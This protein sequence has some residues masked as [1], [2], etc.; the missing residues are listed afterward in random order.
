MENSK[1]IEKNKGLEIPDAFYV[2]SKIAAYLAGELTEK[3]KQELECW[4]EAD[5]ENLRLFEQIVSEENRKRNREE[6]QAFPEGIGWEEFRHKRMRRRLNVYYRWTVYAAVVLVSF[7]LSYYFLFRQQPISLPGRQMTYLPGAYRAQL[8]LSDGKVIDL[9][10]YQ[11]KINLNETMAV[12][13]NQD[14]RLSY[15]DTLMDKKADM[16]VVYNQIDVPKC[17]EYQLRL[18]D[19]SVV[20]LN[21]QTRLRF[22]VSFTGNTREVELTGEAYFE[23]AKDAEKPF[24]VHAKGHS[25]T[26]V[27]TKFNISAFENEE[28]I[29]TTLVTGKVS[30]GG[31][32]MEEPV[33]L[34]PNEQFIFNKKSRQY[35]IH[36]VDVQDYTAWKDGQ[37]RFRDVRLDEIMRSIERWYGVEAEYVDPETKAYVFGLNFSRHETIAP[38]LRIF[39]QNGKI[40]I[41]MVGNKLKIRK[42][43]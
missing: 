26:V 34:A 23:V 3:E 37:F 6:F 41:Q 14:N 38:F 31:E 29:K 5:Q 4:K 32:E 11:G 15:Q 30:V 42:G 24:I 18:S 35:K 22:P 28:V 20:F 12:I 8:T 1:K 17:G 2:A 25:V 9:E 10:K 21:S 27:G 39:E 43:R 33:V 36:R 19:G 16:A 40:D 7:G 13:R